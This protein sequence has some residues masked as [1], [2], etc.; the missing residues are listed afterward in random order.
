MWKNSDSGGKKHILQK[1]LWGCGRVDA[2]KAFLRA[3]VFGVTA[4]RRSQ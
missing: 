3:F 2:Y 4:E 1:Y